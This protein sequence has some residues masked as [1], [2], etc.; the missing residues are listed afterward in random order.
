MGRRNGEY[1]IYLEF[2]FKKIFTPIVFSVDR[3]DLV[4]N[5]PMVLLETYLI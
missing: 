4:Q 3:I 5:L 2:I 1:P